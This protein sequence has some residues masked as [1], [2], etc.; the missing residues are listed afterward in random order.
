MKNFLSKP[1]LQQTT[2]VGFCFLLLAQ[3]MV[4]ISVVATKPLLNSLSPITML[5]FR[6][7]FSTVILLILHFSSS[8][9]HFSLVKSLSRVDWAFIVGQAL[10]S[11]ILANLIFY[12]GLHHTTASVASMIASTL[13]A[14]VAIFS[15]IFLKEKLTARVLWC[16]FFAVMG[17][18]IINA[19]D[20][21]A[22]DASAIT[23]GLI[24]LLALLPESTY[25]M[26]CKLHQK[27]L[28]I[29]L[30]AALMNAINI[31][32]CLAIMGFWHRPF[33]HVLPGSQW[34]LLFLISIGYSLFY[35][36]WFLGAKS[37]KGG[38]TGL[39]TAFMPI[40]ALIAASLFL[41]EHVAATQLLGM[42]LVIIS[43]GFSVLKKI[44]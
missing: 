28:P 23:G 38:L 43:I 16:I 27:Q 15:I 6:F 31:P 19:H 2:L 17:L 26:L 40:S 37:V 4:G 41:K 25:Y 44:D 12:T 29:F 10:T 35:V 11:G 13:P 34:I 21:Y 5:T 18:L 24:I 7:I 30:V 9:R 36:F 22:K 42:G 1:L 39:T 3:S 33:P 20:F 32:I 14:I 8:K